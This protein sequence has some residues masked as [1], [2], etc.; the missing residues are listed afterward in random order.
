LLPHFWQ[1]NDTEANGTPIIKDVAVAA[2][3]LT[4]FE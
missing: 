3:I 1:T 4:K 2:G